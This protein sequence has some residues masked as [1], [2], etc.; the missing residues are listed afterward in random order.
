MSKIY[1]VV[2]IGAGPAGLS[3]GLYAGRSRLSTLIIEKAREGGQIVNTAEI[4]NYPGALEGDTGPSLIER[5]K[6][7]AVHFG[8]EI[9]Y[10][11]VQ[12]VE[13]EGKTKTIKGLNNTY[14]AKAVILANGAQPATLGCP[15]EK[16]FTGRGVSY[17]ATCDGAFFE[18]LEVFVVGGGDAAIEEA[19]YLTKFARKVTVIHRRDAL[20]AAKSIQEK[21]FANPKIEFMWDSVV[22]ELKGEELLDTLVVENVKTGERTE[23]KADPEDGMFGVFVFIGFRPQ[24]ELYEGKVK[25]ENHYIVTDDNMNT[26]IP[27][28]FAAGDIRAKSLRQVVTAAADGAIAATQAEKYLNEEAG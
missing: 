18:E 6:A 13:L 8:A 17:C 16:E 3:A 26:D 14:Q 11:T 5:M 22:K 12:E 25:M 21:A 19:I 1:D 9:V 7:Q 20:R 23:V 15:G 24:T 2:I 4:A 27:G 10:D 28:V